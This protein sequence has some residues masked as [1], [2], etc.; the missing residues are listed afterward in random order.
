MRLRARNEGSHEHHVSV[1]RL[2]EGRSL[3]DVIH[4]PAG[5]LPVFDVLGGTAGL[6]SGEEN[7]LQLTL[8]PGQYVYMCFVVDQASRREHYQMGMVRALTVVP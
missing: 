2:T 1:A 8:S 3:N 5:A 6:A 4:E 7:V